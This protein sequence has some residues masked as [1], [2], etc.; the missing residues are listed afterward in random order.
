MAS[1][2]ADEEPLLAELRRMEDELAMATRAEAEGAEEL[3]SL[4]DDDAPDQ[5]PGAR[6]RRGRG[7]AGPRRDGAGGGGGRGCARPRSGR[8]RDELQA[9]VESLRESVGGAAD[10]P[11]VSVA[12]EIEWYLLA[13]L[14]TQ[15]SVSLGG[16]LPLLLDDALEGVSHADLHHVLERLE[17]MTEAVQVV[18]VSEDPM[19]WA[20]ADLAGPDRA[21]VVRPG[22][23]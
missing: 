10:E 11:A 8:E 2:L 13:R 14:A 5:A 16:S 18:V 23:V 17:R 9:A 7:R 19:V 22:A 12:D 20:W 1:A 21:A 15:R 4:T 3:R 6:G